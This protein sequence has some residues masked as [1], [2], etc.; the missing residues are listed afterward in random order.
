MQLKP[1]KVPGKVILSGEYA[2]MH[3]G[4][5]VIVPAERFVTV[6]E[7]RENDEPEFT[8]VIKSALEFPIDEI[9][10][11]E[12][13]HGRPR[14][15]LEYSQFFD[16]SNGGN[17]KLGIGLSAA[18]A[19]AVVEY[20]LKRA[21]LNGNNLSQKT[22]ELAHSI[23][24]NTQG[25]IGSGADV[26]CCAYRKPIIFCNINGNPEVH[27]FNGTSGDIKIPISLV[28]S[29]IVSN[30]RD[31]IRRFNHWLE[32]GDGETQ[33]CLEIMKQAGSD[34]AP[35]WFS[36]NH[37]T[38]YGTFD[39]YMDIM[40]N[41]TKRANINYWLDEFNDLD[42]WAR[43]FG[44]RIKPSGAGGGD[45]IILIGNLPVKDLNCQSYKIIAQS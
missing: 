18:E 19:V 12:N 35:H 5:A 41:C 30:T 36:D 17:H 43:Q 14:L 37:D 38:F 20:R 16:C 33:R 11:Y 15:K 28:W 34:L 40:R 31:M 45:M 27:E 7:C 23:H 4:T 44:G 29:G 1:F 3:G 25:N 42:K 9:K 10:D 39:N 21:G 13:A 8:P 26:F 32:Q 2:V 22:A 6:S 24:F